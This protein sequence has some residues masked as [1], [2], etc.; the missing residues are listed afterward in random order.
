MR[1]APEHECILKLTSNEQS[2]VV[3]LSKRR[4]LHRRRGDRRHVIYVLVLYHLKVAVTQGHPVKNAGYVFP[5][6]NFSCSLLLMMHLSFQQSFQKEL[7]L[8]MHS[9]RTTWLLF[10]RNLVGTEILDESS[11]GLKNDISCFLFLAAHRSASLFL[12]TVSVCGVG[13]SQTPNRQVEQI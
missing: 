6:T 5:V 10:A 2:H 3:R 1:R 4:S 12:C 9:S 11:A 13:R 8:K 7:R